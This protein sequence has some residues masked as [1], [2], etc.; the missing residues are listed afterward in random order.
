MLLS[1]LVK[2]RANNFTRR[3]YK[4]RGYTQAEGNEEFWVNV[5]DLMEGSHSEVI[6]ICDYCNDSRDECLI[7]TSYKSY[8]KRVKKGI[9][10]K[11]CC[12]KPECQKKKR[13]ESMLAKYGVKHALQLEGFKDKS[14]ETQIQKYGVIHYNQTLASKERH[15]ETYLKKYSV[16]NPMKSEEIR[17]K[18]KATMLKR[19]GAEHALQIDE[20]KEKAITTTKTLY[21]V[22]NYAQTNEYIQKAQRTSLMR[23]G[24]KNPAQNEE[25]KAKIK[26]TNIYKYGVGHAFQS[27]QVRNKYINTIKAKYGNKYNNAMQIPSIAFKARINANITMKKNGTQIASKTQIYLNKLLGG[28]LNY[29]EGNSWLDIAFL[30]E[31]IYLEYD[32]SGHEVSVKLGDITREQFEHKQLNRY[33]YLKRKGWKEIRIISRNDLLPEDEII[34]SEINKAR[35]WFKETGKGHSHYIIDI[36]NNDYGKLRK[37]NEYTIIDN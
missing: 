27:E 19:Y 13:E 28:D 33:F 6:C 21:G 17:K 10:Q 37:L 1:K 30:E 16:D 15:K 3:W 5:D 23:Y 4:E 31:K 14:R 9:T 11:D 32:G 12:R 35:E 25:V 34:I 29:L 20:F 18:S 22:S 2:V 7:K 8:V 24:C 36:D 26:A